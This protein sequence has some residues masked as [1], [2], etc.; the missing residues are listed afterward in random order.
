[1]ASDK[2]F[3]DSPMKPIGSIPD[4]YKGSGS[5]EYG[6]ES[7]GAFGEHKR[8]S[9]PNGVPEVTYDGNVGTVSG[10]PLG[11]DGGN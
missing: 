9:S 7:A 8:T 5:H 11:K 1:M 4:G 6:G 3:V 2:N 10:E